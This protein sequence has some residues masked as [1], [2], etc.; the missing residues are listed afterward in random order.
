MEIKRPGGRLSVVATPIGNLEDLSRRALRVLEESDLIAAED[1]RHTR[2]LL[3]HYKVHTPLTSYHEHNES[4][5]RPA[6]IHALC[7]GKRIALVTDAGTPCI[8]DPG[9]RLVR[10]A[11][12]AGIEVVAVPGPSAVHAALSVSGFPSDRFAFHGFFPRKSAEADELIAIIRA[13]PGTHV[14]FESPHRLLRSLELLV[15]RLPAVEV[16]VA[17][18]LTKTFEEIVRGAPAEV[19]ERFRRHAPKGE[20]VLMLHMAGHGPDTEALPATDLRNLVE[21]LVQQDGLTRRDAIQRVADQL[22]LPRRRVYAA[23]TR[24]SR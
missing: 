11:H 1:T 4:K 3:G 7:D 19:A 5:R 23:A 10:A 17:R 2:K 15:D 9:S 6:L 20:C 18:E 14:F 8:S 16:C 21:Q 24:K 13:A 22:G 12:E